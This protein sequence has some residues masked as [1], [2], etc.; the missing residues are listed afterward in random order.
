MAEDEKV[1]YIKTE[2]RIQSR[3]LWIIAVLIIIILILL[4]VKFFNP[5]PYFYIFLFACAVA[6][7]IFML[8]KQHKESMYDIIRKVQ[9]ENF[10]NLPDGF[11]NI[12]QGNVQVEEL[13]ENDYVV[14]FKDIG[15]GFQYKNSLIIGTRVRSLY[16][17][18]QDRDKL[19]YRRELAKRGYQERNI[20][21]EASALGLAMPG[22]EE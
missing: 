14:H 21:S 18:T 22:G 5:T 16:N 15:Q 9:L 20:K 17:L 10:N 11:L 6:Y 3:Y 4:I 2:S 8:R 1:K 12:S 13:G 19:E 7:I